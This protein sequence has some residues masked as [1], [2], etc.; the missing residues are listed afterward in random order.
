MFYFLFFKFWNFGKMNYI[1]LNFKNKAFYCFYWMNAILNDSELQALNLFFSVYI[2]FSV[3]SY[4][5]NAK[6]LTDTF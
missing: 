3:H 4:D 6:S 2:Y 5:Q 1:K